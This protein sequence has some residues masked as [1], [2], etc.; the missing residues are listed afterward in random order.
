MHISKFFSI[1]A[2]TFLFF[3]GHILAG[4][5]G[6]RVHAP[7][8]LSAGIIATQAITHKWKNWFK[9]TE[10]DSKKYHLASQ[11]YAHKNLKITSDEDNSWLGS[12]SAI[13]KTL[14]DN[15]DDLLMD[16]QANN[17][18]WEEFEH[19]K[20]LDEQG[21]YFSIKELNRLAFL[22]AL[23]KNLIEY[24][25]DIFEQHP[26]TKPSTTQAPDQSDGPSI[27]R[28]PTAGD[29]AAAASSS[30]A[31]S[32]ENDLKVPFIQLL[33][34]KLTDDN[35]QAIIMIGEQRPRFSYLEALLTGVQENLLTKHPEVN[36]N[37][38]NKIKQDQ[39]KI[40]EIWKAILDDYPLQQICKQWDDV[41]LLFAAGLTA[42]QL[43]EFGFTGPQLK[44][45]GLSAWNLRHHGV[46]IKEFSPYPKDELSLL[47][48]TLN[49]FFQAGVPIHE[50]VQYGHNLDDLLSA[51]YTPQMFDLS[52]SVLRHQLQGFTVTQLREKGF[53][54][55]TLAGV[56]DGQQLHD[57][58]F[59]FQDL[60][61]ADKVTIGLRAHY[62]LRYLTETV[63]ITIQQLR[64]AGA[65]I[66]AFRHEAFTAR[67]LLDG[68]FT[69]NECMY[70]GYTQHE[71]DSGTWRCVI[72]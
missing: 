32:Q 35:Q 27:F 41:Q 51:G 59:R 9:P 13:L 39:T 67:E 55:L 65:S 69:K 3:P 30:G 8:I 14:D 44:R 61:D 29:G 24:F 20:Q 47:G 63:G 2:A 12:P 49:D 11:K 31:Q 56:Y 34:T 52:P 57:A 45:A 42:A 4:D 50:L 18:D 72:Q 40:E 68:G 10:I 6:V 64:H 26:P 43:I 33:R 70:S 58:G 28:A 5:G 66:R 22:Y 53:D 46:E 54:W 38:S 19:L 25:G 7:G 16:Q 48:I 15:Q 60:N 71:I 17:F 1:V 37:I 36:L 23:K 62:S 21:N